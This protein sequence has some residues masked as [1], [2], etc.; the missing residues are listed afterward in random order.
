MFE[1]GGIDDNRD[2]IDDMVDEA[3]KNVEGDTVNVVEP[4][5]PPKNLRMARIQLDEELAKR[6]HK[7]EMAEFKKRQSE[8][9]VAEEA[10]R[11]TIKAEINQ[12]LDDI[13]AMIEADFEMVKD[14]GKKDDSSSKQVGSMKKRAGLKLKPKSTKKLKVMKEQ[15]S[16]E[17]EQEKRSSDFV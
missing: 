16:T 15:E 9:V 17:D 4:E 13:Q 2:D 5:K 1:E 7:E 6:M 10:S 14:S 3:M 11:A 8:I 12:E